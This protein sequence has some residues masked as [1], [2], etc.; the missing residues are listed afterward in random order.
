MLLSLFLLNWSALSPLRAD[1]LPPDPEFLARKAEVFK[2]FHVREAK[3][4]EFPVTILSKDKVP[5]VMHDAWSGG[6]I[7]WLDNDTIIYVPDAGL[8]AQ[9]LTEQP[10]ALSLISLNLKTYEKKEIAK[11][12]TD[13]FC[14]DYESRNIKFVGAADEG[15]IKRRA[16]FYGRLGEPLKS[17]IPPPKQ[18]DTKPNYTNH[19][20][21]TFFPALPEPGSSDRTA[22]RIADGYVAMQRE[23]GQDIPGEFFFRAPNGGVKDFKLDTAT[24]SFFQYDYFSKLYWFYQDTHWQKNEPDGIKIWRLDKSMNVVSSEFYRHG[25]WAYGYPLRASVRP[26]FLINAT[27]IGGS[28]FTVQS[29]IH[30]LTFLAKKD[31]SITEVAEDVLSGDL[32]VSPDGCKA[33]TPR[34]VSQEQGNPK[35]T[36]EFALL[37]IC[38]NGKGEKP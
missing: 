31:G 36:G 8:T 29:R 21:C 4:G 5:P 22:I 37:Q 3:P 32:R 6:D 9:Q 16:I 2:K 11:V 33:I 10:G 20:D 28:K 13:R 24:Q 34:I 35:L 18:A 15:H 7:A 14:Y 17:F 26:G 27:M 1:G 19:L 12:S 23:F 30:D 38:N 25:P